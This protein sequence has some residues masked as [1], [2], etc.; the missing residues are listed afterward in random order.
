M[1]TDLNAVKAYNDAVVKLNT[2]R[3]GLLTQNGYK[4]TID[5]K[6]GAI[7]NLQVDPY[8]NYGNFQQLLN[9]QGYEDIAAHDAGAS[10]GFTGGLANQPE[11]QLANQHGAARTSFGSNLM[12]Q[13]ANYDTQQADAAQTRDSALWQAQ[14]A[15][16]LNAVN[17]A[18][19]NPA[20]YS[21]P[22]PYGSQAV[23][24]SIDSHPGDLATWLNQIANT[25]FGAY[26]PSARTTAG[27]K[28]APM[29]PAPRPISD[30]LNSAKV[31]AKAQAARKK[32]GK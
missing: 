13:F 5:P 6:T 23:Q 19:F 7:S 1:G 25:H 2:Q 24:N 21:T 10:R 30:V 29:K 3:Q 31:A 11:A 26:Q 17:N 16:A 22:D 12:G 20:D 9:N 15:A 27:A 4:A 28:A 18:D 14:L 8:N 32:G